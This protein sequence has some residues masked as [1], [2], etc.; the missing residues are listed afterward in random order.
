MIKLYIYT[1][2]VVS[3][4]KALVCCEFDTSGQ[5]VIERNYQEILRQ[6][7]NTTP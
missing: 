1:T 5:I 2:V 4:K 7:E 3:R 6:N